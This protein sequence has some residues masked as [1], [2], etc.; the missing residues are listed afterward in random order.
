MKKFIMLI[1]L[2]GSGKSTLARVLAKNVF[3]SV[4]SSDQ[5]REELLND[6]NSQ[7]ANQMVFD[8]VKKRIKNDLLKGDSEYVVMDATNISKKRRIGFLRDLKKIECEKHAIWMCT[9]IEECLKRNRERERV[10]PDEVI[11]RMYKNFNPPHKS[12]GFDRIEIVIPGN[13]EE[14]SKYT[15][16]AFFELADNY[17]QENKH[18][19]LTLGEHCR[20]TQETVASYTA[21]PLLQIAARLHDNGKPYT[22]SYVNGRGETTTEKHYYQHHCVGSYNIPLYMWNMDKNMDNDVVLYIANVVYYHMHPMM[23]WKTEKNVQKSRELLGDRMFY[24]IMLLNLADTT[25]H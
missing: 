11:D 10:V 18:H 22:A 12:E 4:Y 14:V 25:A 2:P 3:A 17:N 24:D 23:E 21:N 20:K 13:S 15:E 7:D 1:G 5:I 8:E 6:V 19:K 16:A 9:P